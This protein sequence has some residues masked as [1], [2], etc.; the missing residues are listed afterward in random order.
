MGV[1]AADETAV[2]GFSGQM[3]QQ[4][5]LRCSDYVRQ[6]KGLIFLFG[7]GGGAAG[8]SVGEIAQA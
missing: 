7:A 3:G 8:I 2:A 4:V 1:I 6:I 5:K